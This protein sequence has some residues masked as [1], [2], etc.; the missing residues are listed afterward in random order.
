MSKLFIV[1]GLPGSGKT[2][3][4]SELAFEL[5]IPCLHKDFIKE[6]LY[7]LLDLKTLDDSKKI[8][9]CSINLLYKIA[10]N[11]M[12]KGADLMIECSC[13]WNED[14]D[15]FKT[16]QNKYDLDLYSI[17]CEIDQ[18]IRLKRFVDRPRHQAHHD[19]ERLI[20]DKDSDN[21]SYRKDF[22]YNQMPGKLIKIKTDKPVEE[23]IKNIEIQINNN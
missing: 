18:K 11:V 2:T 1:C 16:W 8:G 12:S 5:G 10:E 22:D 20:V 19:A 7:E 15:L 14:I 23:L 9:A 4:A 6:N 17:V 21:W 3:L 13:N